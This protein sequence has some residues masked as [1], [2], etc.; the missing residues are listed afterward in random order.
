[1]NGNTQH[2]SFLVFHGQAAK[3]E[4]VLSQFSSECEQDSSG[5][6][7]RDCAL[8]C[9]ALVWF[10]D[11]VISV[12]DVKSP[13]LV[14]FFV[15]GTNASKFLW[16]FWRCS[17]VKQYWPNLHVAVNSLAREVHMHIRIIHTHVRD[18]STF[19]VEQ[20][21]DLT[22]SRAQLIRLLMKSPSVGYG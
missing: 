18:S 11:C 7:Q 10:L 9:F 22:S 4:I 14:L 12:G 17:V 6:L 21:L 5:R 20:W 1:M 19:Q 16:L 2:L 3:Q 13:L 15:M 8:N